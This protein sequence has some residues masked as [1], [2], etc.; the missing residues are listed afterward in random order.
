[1]VTGVQTK[2]YVMVKILEVCKHGAIKTQLTHIVSISYRR[3]RR[4]MAELVDRRFLRFLASQEVYI[5]T[6]RGYLFLD[7]LK[8]ENMYSQDSNKAATIT[9]ARK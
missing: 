8:K 1:V 7:K 4:I 6:H 9:R 3:L 5:T 2:E